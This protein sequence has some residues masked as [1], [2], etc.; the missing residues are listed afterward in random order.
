MAEEHN[1]MTDY[2]DLMV[3]MAFNALE[4]RE[5]YESR[6]LAVI[7]VCFVLVIVLSGFTQYYMIS[8]LVEA[9]VETSTTSTEVTHSIDAGG[10]VNAS[11]NSTVT[12]GDNNVSG[13]DLSVTVKK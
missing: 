7:C 11:S 5:K 6:R 12:T 4:K 9:G 13:N 2:R 1:E 3:G 8:K 10:D